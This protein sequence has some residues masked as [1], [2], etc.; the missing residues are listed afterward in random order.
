[1]ALKK[2]DVEQ[3]IREQRKLL[4]D[5]EVARSACR[6][7]VRH[8]DVLI[9]KRAAWA[10]IF[11]R[12]AVCPTRDK[13]IT[14]TM[15]TTGA[16]LFYV[17]EFV[18]DLDN[19]LLQVVLIHEAAHVFFRHH[20]INKELY[21]RDK[22]LANIGADLAIHGCFEKLFAKL[23]SID[24]C[25]PAHG[26]YAEYPVN[27]SA[28]WYIV[29]LLKKKKE[30]QH[31]QTDADVQPDGESASVD[32][33]SGASD[34]G[35]SDADSASD[36]GA[37]DAES[38]VS[39]ESDSGG[40]GQSGSG[41]AEGGSEGGNETGESGESE[42]ADSN[43]TSSRDGQA[44]EG[45]QGDNPRRDE[46]VEKSAEEK[47]KEAGSGDAHGGVIILEDGDTEEEN[48]LGEKVGESDGAY[49]KAGYNTCEHK[50]GLETRH[51]ITTD[52]S[53]RLGRIFEK[54]VVENTSYLRPKRR[55]HCDEMILPCRFSK[56]L[57]TVAILIDTSGSMDDSEVVSGFQRVNEIAESFPSTDIVIYQCSTQIDW[58]SVLTIEPGD[59]FRANQIDRSCSG[60]TD[61]TKALTQI[62][63]HCE[64]SVIVVWS[65]MQWQVGQTEEPSC[66]V[67]WASTD[68]QWFKKLE[69]YQT[70]DSFRY[71][72]TMIP[73]FGEQVQLTEQ[74]LL[75]Y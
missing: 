73:Q 28:E 33:D 37:S 43:P 24:A 1:M 68:D 45:K 42:D 4:A 19:G 57:G 32:A 39:N 58:D 52:L 66:R 71:S 3:Y 75:S 59:D 6:R 9:H 10:P 2:A 26:E 40:D 61:L 47:L 11:E 64:P 55:G 62:E 51:T 53:E 25:F 18:Q 50:G 54:N 31:E 36:S 34:S 7:I 60:G 5:D 23:K 63:E 21:N 12:W 69:G 20:L 49:S 13:E 17:P 27:K 65:D 16:H 38:S 15:A 56:S 8:I 41:E 44:G 30:D 14:S 29:E 70:G 48:F 67:L 72:K 22:R 74:E 46:P 35:A